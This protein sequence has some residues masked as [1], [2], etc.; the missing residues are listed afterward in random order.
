M[1][2]EFRSPK[3]TPKYI[4]RKLILTPKSPHIETLWCKNYENPI[5]RPSH[6]WT[7]GHLKVQKCDSRVWRETVLW[8]K[9]LNFEILWYGPF[10]PH[11]VMFDDLDVWLAVVAWLLVYFICWQV[12]DQID[13]KVRIYA[14]SYMLIFIF[15]WLGGILS[16]RLSE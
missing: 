11:T 1:R 2:K 7:V 8:K 10:K 6:S 13:A 5:D 4:F 12:T 3:W 14:S 15:S 16:P 9:I